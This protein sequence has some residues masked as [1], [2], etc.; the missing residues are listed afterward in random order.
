[1]GDNSEKG[2][3]G[4]GGSVCMDIDAEEEGGMIGGFV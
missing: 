3:V 2:T 1:M 4:N